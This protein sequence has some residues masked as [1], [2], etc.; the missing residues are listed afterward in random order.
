MDLNMYLPE[1]NTK[2]VS[3][4]GWEGTGRDNHKGGLT[5][6]KNKGILM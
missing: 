2:T 5:L 4:S 1:D 6:L 3:G